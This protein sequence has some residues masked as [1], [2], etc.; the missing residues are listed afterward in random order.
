MLWQNLKKRSQVFQYE[1]E[2]S[3]PYTQW[4]DVPQFQ[5]VD[6]TPTVKCVAINVIK[7]VFDEK[8]NL[9]NAEIDLKITGISEKLTNDVNQ[10][11]S[12]LGNHICLI[13]NAFDS[14][15]EKIQK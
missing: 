5:P 14:K 12:Y 9:K 7:K 10:V 15:I 11:S 6:H 8:I 3:I 1:I 4:S 2:E 13:T